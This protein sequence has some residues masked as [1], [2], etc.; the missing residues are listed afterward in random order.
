MGTQ[1][2][3]VG[4]GPAGLLLAWMGV[5]AQA[6]PAC[7]PLIH[8]NRE[9]GVALLFAPPGRGARV[10][11]GNLPPQPSRC[12][13]L[14]RGRKCNSGRFGRTIRMKQAVILLRIAGVPGIAQGVPINALD[15][16]NGAKNRQ[17][18]T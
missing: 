5:L 15:V 8:T 2:D 9:R 14:K 7:E 18:L 12:S 16:G 17:R 1:L 4:A 10:G 3:I 11:Q 13:F 6:R